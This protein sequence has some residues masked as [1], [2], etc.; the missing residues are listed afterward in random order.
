MSFH[1]PSPFPKQTRSAMARYAKV[2]HKK[3]AQMLGFAL[4]LDTP[5]GW[6][7][8]SQSIAKR[9]TVKERAGIAFTALKSLPQG[10]AAT[11]AE[12]NFAVASVPNAPLFNHSD[13]AAFWADLASQS[14]LAAYCLASFRAMSKSRQSDFLHFVSGG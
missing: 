8:F 5:H 13:E 11:V 9:L 3:A 6:W 1:S 4:T 10:H 12:M 2:E 7:G 14:E